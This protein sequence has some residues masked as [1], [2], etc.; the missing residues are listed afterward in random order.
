MVNL[1]FL[2]KSFPT[3][4]PTD[5]GVRQ[6]F[7]GFYVFWVHNVHAQLRAKIVFGVFKVSHLLK[8]WLCIR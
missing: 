8:L 1:R 2:L 3:D 6:L 7:S 5:A 4:F